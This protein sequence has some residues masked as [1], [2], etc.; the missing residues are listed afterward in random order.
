MAAETTIALSSIEDKRGILDTFISSLTP[1]V[2][3]GGTPLIIVG[4]TSADRR[5]AIYEFDLTGIP[6]YS[7]ITSAI[8]TLNLVVGAATGTED[9]LA[10]EFFRLTAGLPYEISTLTLNNYDGINQWP[11]ELFDK[12]IVITDAFPTAAGDWVIND[13]K[14]LFSDSI[15]LGENYL[16]LVVRRR[17]Q[18]SNH[19][20]IIINSSEDVT[21]GDRPILLITY[22]PPEPPETVIIGNR[23]VVINPVKQLIK[24]HKREGS[25]N[26]QGG[27]LYVND[28]GKNTI[29][30][31]A[32]E[33]LI[34]IN[35]GIQ[36]KFVDGGL[37]GLGDKR[38]TNWQGRR[39]TFQYGWNT[40][41]TAGT[42]VQYTTGLSVTSVR[43]G[44]EMEK[45]GSIIAITMIIDINAINAT[46]VHA[47]VYKN[48]AVFT[49]CKASVSPAPIV[50]NGQV[51]TVSFA[52]G[53]HTFVAGD[54]LT[55]ARTWS[56]F[57]ITTDD[58][59]MM[60]EVEY[61]S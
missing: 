22:F 35:D 39:A 46:E 25:Y 8:L 45:A 56:G 20:L 12:S 15:R 41:N 11:L 55:M 3:E 2:P 61:D 33:T 49:N 21:V 58:T 16:H 60:M 34:I 40:T 29:Q 54:D 19:R 48:D 59:S 32:D 37:D 23:R 5:D 36:A 27:I 10:V 53:T 50:A 31:S 6:K 18:V 9:E 43:R 13:L 7:Q 28:D 38:L 57:S 17:Q 14:D 47:Q 30:N 24:Q 26:L 4:T 1:N 44:Y 42:R 52:I 51:A